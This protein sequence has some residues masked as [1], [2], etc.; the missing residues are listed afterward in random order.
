M[1][2][3]PESDPESY[4][5][6]MASELLCYRCNFPTNPDE[7]KKCMYTYTQDHVNP[8]V[9]GTKCDKVICD[10]CADAKRLPQYTHPAKGVS[11]CVDHAFTVKMQNRPMIGTRPYDDPKELQPEKVM[12]SDCLTVVTTEAWQ[13]AGMPLKIKIKGKME[14]HWPAIGHQFTPGEI[15]CFMEGFICPINK[16]PKVRVRPEDHYRWELH[17]L[18]PDE[19]KTV[20]K[21]RKFIVLDEDEQD[22]KYHENEKMFRKSAA[23]ERFVDKL[24]GTQKCVMPKGRAAMLLDEDELLKLKTKSDRHKKSD[25][26]ILKQKMEAY[27]H[28][29]ESSDNDME[30]TD[31]SGS[32]SS[33]DEDNI[34]DLQFKPEARSRNKVQLKKQK[35]RWTK[36]PAAVKASKSAAPAAVKASKSA[37]KAGIKK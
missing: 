17:P 32:S 35:I 23:D 6:D 8:A 34:D 5:D 28:D 19:Y 29:N 37:A 11:Y 9:A 33:A 30:G 26:K 13:K 25:E 31:N 10:D 36:P 24:Y 22:A 20:H 14:N 21:P 7:S 2:S 15:N 18:P 4:S 12:A 1:A 3:D 27:R 16:F